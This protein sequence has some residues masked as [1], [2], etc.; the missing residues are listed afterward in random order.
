MC[1][2]RRGRRRRLP[3]MV[4]WGKSSKL[5]LVAISY[6]SRP[7]FVVVNWVCSRSAQVASADISFSG[8]QTSRAVVFFLAS[9]GSLLSGRWDL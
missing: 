5:S 8:E 4:S 9:D 7:F 1:T 2:T 3:V 6:V